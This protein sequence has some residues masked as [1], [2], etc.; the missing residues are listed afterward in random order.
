[1]LRRR[2]LQRSLL[3]VVPLLAWELA[4][5]FGLVPTIFFPAPSVIVSTLVEL[6]RS[7]EIAEHLGA[8][9]TRVLVGFLAGACCGTVVGW[10]LGWWP[11]LRW[12]VDP[13]IAALHPVPKVAL[14]PLVLVVFGLGEQSLILVVALSAFFPAVISTAAGVRDLPPIHFEIAASCGVPGSV[15]LRR[16][17][18]PGSLPAVMTG[19]R[20]A[21]NVAI[22]VCISVELVAAET[23]LGNRIWFSW[24]TFRTEEL[25]AY[26]VLISLLGIALT[27]VLAILGAAITPWKRLER[28]TQSSTLRRAPRRARQET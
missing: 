28:S 17:V 27:S 24:E 1:M 10:F 8:T 13:V 4:A 23:G 14:L 18:V 7:G 25:W 15:V 16:I 12:F 5:R 21:A 22:L 11:R 3:L 19:F 2:S 20:L 6:G 26:L 9:L